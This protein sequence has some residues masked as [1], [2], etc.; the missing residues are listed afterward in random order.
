MITESALVMHFTTFFTS[1]LSLRLHLSLSNP[2]RHKF[3][4]FLGHAEQ[5]N[6]YVSVS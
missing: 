1:L 6:S 5:I 3:I 2:Q 4:I